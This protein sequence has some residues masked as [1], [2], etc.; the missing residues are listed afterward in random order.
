MRKKI[1]FRK[2]SIVS[3]M[4]IN[5]LFLACLNTIQVKSINENSFL[6]TITNQDLFGD[7]NI[8]DKLELEDTFKNNNIVS[9]SSNWLKFEH[10]I[11]KYD[12]TQENYKERGSLTTIYIAR[13]PIVSNISYS[14]LLEKNLVNGESIINLNG[15]K[16]KVRLISGG[17]T[18]SNTQN[19]WDLLIANNSLHSYSNQDLSIGSSL[20]GTTL[21][22]ESVNSSAFA[23]G[24]FSVNDRRIIE[25]KNTKLQSLGW[26]PVLELISEIPS[27][28]PSVPTQPTT[29]TEPSEPTQP[30]KPTQPSQPTEPTKPSEPTQPSKPTQPTEQKKPDNNFTPDLGFSLRSLASS[31]RLPSVLEI[32]LFSNLLEER[33]ATE[34]QSKYINNFGRKE[35]YYLPLLNN[36]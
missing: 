12:P 22:Q 4:C 6:G 26:R 7:S 20:G 3:L 34:I 32:R 29:P 21:I 27:T 14:E 13:N 15:F 23:R 25:S 30:S 5:L 9:K 36:Y 35:S 11:P 17:N 31:L 33:P 2:K 19:E 8:V 1:R 24:V 28:T 16:Y 10:K 18:T